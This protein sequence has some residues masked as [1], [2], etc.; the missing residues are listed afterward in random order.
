MQSKLLE[1]D[2]TLT[3]DKAIDFARTDEA[4]SYQLHDIR[5]ITTNEVHNLKHT[6]KPVSRPTCCNCGT[7]HDLASKAL[8]PAYGSKCK[9]CGKA[10]HWKQFCRSSKANKPHYKP[11]KGPSKGKPRQAVHN[12]GKQA[13]PDVSQ[14]HIDTILANG[15]MEKREAT[16]ELQVNI[17]KQATPIH[18]KVDTSVE[19]NVIPV[20][21]YKQLFPSAPCDSVCTPLGIKP[22]TCM[23]NLKYI[24]LSNSYPFHVVNTGGPTIL[25]LPTCIDMNLVTLNYTITHNES[26]PVAGITSTPDGNPEAKKQLI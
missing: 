18:C 9:A 6:P 5:G 3:F 13:T 23:L 17:G 11:R 8:C 7:V 2:A 4:T 25:G 1:Q 12:I 20:N 24:D 26:T 14:L 21:T 22:S 15:M 16:F 10:N 19:G